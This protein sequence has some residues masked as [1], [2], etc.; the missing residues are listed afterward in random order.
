MSNNEAFRFALRTGGRAQEEKSATDSSYKTRDP[1]RITT[2]TT[3]GS[4]SRCFPKIV[5]R[6]CAIFPRYGPGVCSCGP[7]RTGA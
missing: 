5:R 1:P 7:D 2:G 6:Q 4:A 3:E